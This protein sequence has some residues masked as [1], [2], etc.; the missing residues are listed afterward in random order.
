MMDPFM[1]KPIIYNLLQRD[2]SELLSVF[3]NKQFAL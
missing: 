1:D 3:L 2:V